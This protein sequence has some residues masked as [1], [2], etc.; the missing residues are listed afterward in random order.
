MVPSQGS[1]DDE[2]CLLFLFHKDE[3]TWVKEEPQERGKSISLV[4]KGT[5]QTS[6]T[7]SKISPDEEAVKEKVVARES[8]DSEDKHENTAEKYSENTRYTDTKCSVEPENKAKTMIKSTPT[9]ESTNNKSVSEADPNPKV[10][11]PTNS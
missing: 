3:A 2:I 1:K 11:F 4:S 10:C 5:L 6:S 9:A 7:I 8:A